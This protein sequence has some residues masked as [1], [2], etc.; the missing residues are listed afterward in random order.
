MNDEN[1]KGKKM[2]NKFITFFN[3]P[4]NII[5]VVFAVL[6]TLTVLILWAF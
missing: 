4:S 1:L 5:L 2:L 3:K 6:L